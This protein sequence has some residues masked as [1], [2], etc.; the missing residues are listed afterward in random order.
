MT[1]SG[2]AIGILA[3]EAMDVATL[4]LVRTAGRRRH[5][6]I[7]EATRLGL[8]LTALAGLLRLLIELLG[9]GGATALVA[10]GQAYI[11]WR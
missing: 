6:L 1:R 4:F 3:L 9:L 7:A 11:G 2:S 10:E 8:T 5:A